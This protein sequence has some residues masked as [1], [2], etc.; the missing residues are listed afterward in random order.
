[1]V[2]FFLGLL[3]GS[4]RLTCLYNSTYGSLLMVMLWHVS[5]NVASAFAM[6]SSTYLVAVMS[7][8]VPIG[9]LVVLLIWKPARLSPAPKHTIADELPSAPAHQAPAVSERVPVTPGGW[10]AP[11]MDLLDP[12]A[13]SADVP[14][15]HRSIDNLPSS[16]AAAAARA[17]PARRPAPGRRRGR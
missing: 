12:R 11:R 4:I 6:A 17:I 14:D 13:M 15:A 16:A 8:P 7:S 10:A 1:M 5:L 2:F 3:A 9:A